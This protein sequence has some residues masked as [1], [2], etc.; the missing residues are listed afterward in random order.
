MIVHE[1]QMLLN[2]GDCSE[3]DL[4]SEPLS[5][6]QMERG[7]EASCELSMIPCNLIQQVKPLLSFRARETQLSKDL[8]N[9]VMKSLS[10]MNVLR[11]ISNLGKG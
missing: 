8:N 11:M 1:I 4:G 6:I 2:L 9:N 7:K 5:L 10:L 3:N